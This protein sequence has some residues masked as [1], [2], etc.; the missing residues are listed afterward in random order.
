MINLGNKKVSKL[1]V[2]SNVIYQD[3][4]GWIPLELPDGVTGQVFFKDNGDGTAKLA[5]NLCFDFIANQVVKLLSP[6]QGYTFTSAKWNVAQSNG[7]VEGIVSMNELRG[8]IPPSTGVVST[9]IYEGCIFCSKINL[10]NNFKR[11]I[12][13]TQSSTITGESSADPA[14]IGIAKV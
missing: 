5:G 3:S 7:Y 12:A 2:G 8:S 1:L 13:L 6:P 14:I 11:T 4:D 10:G 9:E